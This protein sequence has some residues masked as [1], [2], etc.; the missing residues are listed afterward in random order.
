ML[1]RDLAAPF[2]A[3]LQR[4]PVVSVTGPRQSGKT[5][6]V[7]A[8]VDKPYANLEAPDIRSFALNDP[9]SFLAQYPDGAVLDEAQRAPVLLSYL[10]ID[11]DAANRPG[12]WVLTG[13]H[14]PLLRSALAQSLAGRVALLRLL[15]LSLGEW[16]AWGRKSTLEA[17]LID[18]GYPRLHEARIPAYQFYSDYLAT[19]LE[20]DV[21][22]ILNIKDLG[23]F[24]RFLGLF[25]GR[26]A[27][28]MN[29]A[30]LGN[31]AGA[32][33]TT[34]KS[35]CSVLEASEVAVALAPWFANIGKRL[36]RSP[37]WYF[38][39]SG[40]ASSLLGS[41]SPTMLMNHPHR[42]QIFEG[43]VVGEAMKIIAHAASPARLHFFAAPNCE[44]DLLI[45]ANG[46]TLAVEIKAGQSPAG[47]WFRGLTQVADIPSMSVDARM[48]VYGGDAEER[49]VQGHVC[50][51]WLF[52]VRLCEWLAAHGAL[53][54]WAPPPGR[55]MQLRACCAP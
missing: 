2:R 11:V 32:N 29:Y 31:D 53:P 12:R 36:I 47:D 55:E 39:D 28:I 6:L 14:Q 37:K 49:R 33:Q 21:R 26:H 34:V 35:W 1:P 54:D 41:S 45:E 20:R 40:L 5:T 48:V 52:P 4:Y 42:G 38:I 50:P 25:A 16:S 22:Q 30:E 18:G 51:W 3:A 8:L 27:Q 17:L 7:R 19:Y 43:L 13:S 9:R 46:R 24:Q 44:V 23:T 15:P 10:Q